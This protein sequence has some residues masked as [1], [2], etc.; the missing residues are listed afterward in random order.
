LFCGDWATGCDATYEWDVFG[1]IDGGG[2]LC[3]LI[4]WHQDL[5]GAATGGIAA[6]EAFFLEGLKL[7]GNTGS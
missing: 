1:L 3:G 5:Y 2:I 7:V 4:F 6:D